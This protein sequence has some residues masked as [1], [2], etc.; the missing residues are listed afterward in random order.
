MQNDRGFI[1]RAPRQRTRRTPTEKKKKK[2]RRRRRKKNVLK[3]GPPAVQRT[4]DRQFE[5][6]D[7][8]GG[9]Q[10]IQ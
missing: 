6:K 8:T 9:H 3:I 5:Q 1:Y 7:D 4:D 10:M 2:R